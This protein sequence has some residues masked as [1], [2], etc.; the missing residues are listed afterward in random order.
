MDFISTILDDVTNGAQALGELDFAKLCR[1]HRVPEPSRQVVQRGHKGRIYLD[2][3][4][5]EHRAGAEID[6]GQHGL[7]LK[8]V[9]DSLRDNELVIG[10][11][12]VLRI[13]VLGL[14][15]DPGAFMD[16]VQRLLAGRESSA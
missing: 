15:T 1:E 11:N 6:G 14:R 12:P 7:G 3:Q 16:Q 13:P 9:D 2:V 4:W 10:K 8:R 5:K